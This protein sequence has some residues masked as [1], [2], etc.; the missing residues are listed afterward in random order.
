[1]RHGMTLRKAIQLVVSSKGI[2][3]FIPT[4]PT[5]HQQV[6]V[7]SIP[8]ERSIPANLANPKKAGL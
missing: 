4:F 5:E 1:M 6:V 7:V 8:Y 3:G 2:P